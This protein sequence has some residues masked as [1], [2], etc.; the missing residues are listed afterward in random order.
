MSER[1]RDAPADDRHGE[2]DDGRGEA[3]AARSSRQVQIGYALSLVLLAAVLVMAARTDAPPETDRLGRRVELVELIRAEQSRA[4]ALSARVDEL[5]AQVAEFQERDTPQADAIAALQAQ[6]DEIAAAA[7]LAAVRGPGVEV[8]LQD[9][10]LETSP[11]GDPNDLVIHEQDLQAVI[12]ALWAGGAEAM[13][14]N[15]QRVLATTAIRCVGNTLLLHGAV[16]SPPYVIHAI[17]DDVALRDSLDRDP[18]VTRFRGAVHQ[19][20]LG[21]SVTSLD[22]IEIPA[23]EGTPTLTVARPPEGPQ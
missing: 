18:A 2:A 7:G 21:F 6:V 16:Y 3:T 9:S 10:S 11:R 23:H 17:G 22:E 20:Q 5:A 12:N 8:T 13:A 19:F 1:H 15:G 14:I 4:E